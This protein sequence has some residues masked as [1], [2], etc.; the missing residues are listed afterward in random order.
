MSVQWY[1]SFADGL[2]YV[3][4]ALELHDVMDRLRPIFA[5]PKIVK[6][7]PSSIVL[8]AELQ[9]S[10]SAAQSKFAS[11]CTMLMAFAKSFQKQS[12]YT[13][14]QEVCIC[15]HVLKLGSAKQVV[16]GGENDTHWLQRDFHIYTANVF[17]TEKAALVS[18][19]NDPRSIFFLPSL[20]HCTL[21]RVC[22]S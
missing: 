12:R 15:L 1:K 7:S 13:M 16:H 2:D 22:T 9:M 5:N 17:D 4:D 21:Q 19:T 3:I 8:N 18:L 6:V 20:A 14:S 10:R 11:T